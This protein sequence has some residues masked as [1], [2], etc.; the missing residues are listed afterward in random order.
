MSITAYKETIDIGIST[1]EEII[2]E[3]KQGKPVI[4][5][6]DENRENEG[7]IIIAAEHATPENIN[8]MARFARGLI[9]L[10]MDPNLIDKLG[11]SLMGT[12][13]DIYKTAFTMSI[14]ARDNITTGIS[15]FDRSHTIQLAVQEGTTA[16][17]FVTP[18]HVFPLR[19]KQ[20][21]VLKRNGHTEAGVDFARLAGLKPAAAI[22]EV[23]NDDGTMARLDDLKKFAHTHNLKIGTIHDLILYR[24][25]HDV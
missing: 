18:G 14:D 24:R 5:I 4:I 10:A 2:S 15:A 16:Q 11:L 7:D 8:F 13:E 9:C 20:D 17:D 22:C 6:D 25:K 21:G 12:P 23:M 3:I 1:V 19:A